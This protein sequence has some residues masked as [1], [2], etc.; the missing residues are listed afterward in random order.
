MSQIINEVWRSIDGYV[1]YQVSNVG[2]I[3]NANTGKV[4]RGISH[5]E[6]YLHVKLTGTQGRRNEF[7]HRLVAREFIDNP[8][9]KRCVD[10]INYDKT[11]NAVNNLRWATHSENSRNMSKRNHAS[12]K[13]LGVCWEPRRQTW[14]ASITTNGHARHVGYFD[15]EEDAAKAYDERAI[16]EHGAYANLNFP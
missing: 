11:D 4:L 9:N 15:I 5:T 6:G 13:Y 14:R 12:S 2:R 7:I 10:H 8:D 3:R 1:N 16:A